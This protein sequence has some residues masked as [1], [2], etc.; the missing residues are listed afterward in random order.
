MFGLGT[1][2]RDFQ[3]SAE[4]SNPSLRNRGMREPANFT[5]PVS[6]AIRRVDY[7]RVARNPTTIDAKRGDCFPQPDFTGLIPPSKPGSDKLGGNGKG[8]LEG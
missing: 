5:S 8:Q 1:G 6:A 7:F 4:S 3:D 2:G